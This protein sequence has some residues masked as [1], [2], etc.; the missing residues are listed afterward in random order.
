MKPRLPLLAA[1]AAAFALPAA[2]ATWTG[3]TSGSWATSTNW[4]GTPPD[5][6]TAQAIVYNGSSTANLTQTLNASYTVTGITLT[7]PTGAVTVSNGT[8]TGNT[9][10]IGSGGI[11]M[12]AATQNLTLSA[13]LNIGA[14]Q[15]WTVA[16][17]RT[18]SGIAGASTSSGSGTGNINMVQSGTGTA[19]IIFNQNGNTGSGQTG[20]SNYSGN[21]TINSNVKVQS[22]GN[23][24]AAFGTGT[25][26]LAGG[27]LAQRDG[28]WTWGNN[29]DVTAA[30]VI[31]NDSSNGL[32]RTLKLL[33]TL[34][35]SNSSGLTFTNNV[36]GGTRT[37]DVGFILAGANASTYTT[38]TISGNSRVRVGGND[39]AS[40]ASSGINAGNR[41]SL[42]TGD[43]TLSASTSELA[44]T[45]TDAHTVANKI[46][47]N[48]TVVIGGNTTAQ[49]GTS[50]QV[51][52]LSGA[53]DYTGGTRVSRS[54]LNLTGSL[55]SAI[56][57]DTS[58]SISG[59]GSTT[60]L[61]TL[62]SGSNIVL[63]GGNTTT[64]ITTNG[65]TFNGSNLVTFLS[66]P[67]TSTQYVVFN[68]GVGAVTNIGN[69]T[70]EYRGSLTDDPSNQRYV[71][72]LAA[73]E[74]RTWNT[75]TG[76]WALN[77]GTNFAE[78]DQ[79][80][81]SGDHVTFGDIASD[82]TVTLSGRIV[83]G[84]VT[85][86][87]TANK[88]T[89]AGTA[90]DGTTSLT[91]SAAGTLDLSVANTYSGGTTLNAG[92]L[93]VSNNSGLGTGALTINGGALTTGSLERQ[94]ANNIVLDGNAI[95]TGTAGVQGM[96]LNG[97]I[98]GD[99]GFTKEGSGRVTIANNSNS[100]TGGTTV[101]EGILAISTGALATSSS[102]TIGSTGSL[103]LGSNGTTSINNLSGVAG[104]VIRTDFNL[105]SDGARTL[106]VNQTTSGTYAGT[107]TQGGN[108]PISLIKTG[109]AQLSISGSLNYTGDTTVN[110]GTLAITGGGGI[111]RG[112]FRG[113]SVVSVNSGATLELQN[114]NYNETTAS[115]GGLANT[116]E[117]IVVDGG[118]IRMTGT[119][120][121]GRGVTVNA[122]GAT[123][124][125]ASG[126]T[127]A[128]D[129]TGDGNVAFVYNSNPSLTF[130]GDGSFVFNKAF[131]GTTGALTKNGS[132]TLTLAAASDYTGATNVNNGTLLVNAN[133]S[134]ATGA[135]TVASGATL[136]G[137]GTLGGAVTVSGAI[138]P[139][140]TG[141]GTLTVNNDVT[142]NAGNSWKFNLSNSDNTSDR[143]ALT[144]VFTKGTGGTGDFVF[145][146]MGSTP[147]WNTTYTLVTFDSSSGFTAGIGGNFSY[148][149]LGSGSYSTSFFTLT[150][151]SLTFT[152]IP[153]PSTALGGLLLTAGLLRRRRRGEG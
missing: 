65:A 76:T 77:S 90:I 140:T 116:A 71:F 20:W 127:W 66:A 141:I 152:A 139:G 45:R 28:N 147:L 118:T 119:T 115:L 148:T 91:K 81:F 12:S 8:G 69:L 142:W 128:F 22:Q 15:T 138:A 132:G 52:T 87:N 146:F 40:T 150:S 88:Y 7:S 26:T 35:S 133:N 70:V 72:N 21:I 143:L 2:A 43:V 44:F 6:I 24:A 36:T 61:L 56:T 42:G 98:S 9:L 149:N 122:G 95:F 5:N 101:N 57:V 121:Y 50:T 85:V 126:T 47:G 10:T 97:I 83:P 136:A 3:A 49:A 84:S 111:H 38:T 110:A 112:G 99:G 55:T 144:G 34:T 51:V 54:R 130:A 86:N 59:T 131:S 41:G 13:N 67:L 29:I 105:V 82:S 103:A 102:V 23:A 96:R 11:D 92:T 135:V 60:G 123:F 46:T 4:T 79:K 32:G 117:R 129:N 114:W 53:S 62:A 37:D 30:S 89:F 109:S 153:E 63:A 68:Y 134:S 39:T 93:Q 104:S 137:T 106:S 74:N 120:T 108:R 125:A 78:G 19:I 31:A 33:G 17:G 80:F 58:G 1:A 151:D 48:G 25:I 113:S 14:S 124:E 16:G 18:L 145:D 27:Q 100:F 75:T 94:L 73:A 107:F 64:S